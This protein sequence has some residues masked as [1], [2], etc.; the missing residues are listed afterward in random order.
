LHWH[1]VETKFSCYC[2]IYVCDLATK[3]LN[4]W[5]NWSLTQYSLNVKVLSISFKL[6]PIGYLTWV[7]L[8]QFI[9]LVQLIDELFS[10]TWDPPSYVLFFIQQL[11]GAGNS[12]SK[13][14]EYSN[15]VQFMILFCKHLN[16]I[17]T[18]WI[19]ISTSKNNLWAFHISC[20]SEQNQLLKKKKIIGLSSTCLYVNKDTLKLVP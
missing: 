3:S 2:F 19:Y 7:L 1:L 4:F 18:I 11:K 14:T 20:K 9:I 10:V 16:K 8:V 5:D 13:V 12:I 17:K 15:S 6:E